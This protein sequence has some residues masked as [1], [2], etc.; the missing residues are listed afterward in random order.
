MR[1]VLPRLRSH[2]ASAISFLRAGSSPFHP[3][4]RAFYFRAGSSPP[5]RVRNPRR[6][7]ASRPQSPR[8]RPAS[9]STTSSVPK[10][11]SA[12]SMEG[13]ILRPGS[14]VRD[15]HHPGS[16]RTAI[17]VSMLSMDGDEGFAAPYTACSSDATTAGRRPGSRRGRNRRN[18]YG[19]CGGGSGS[20]MRGGGRGGGRRQPSYAAPDGADAAA[21]RSPPRRW[22]RA[23][24]GTWSTAWRAR[25]TPRSATA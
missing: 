8:S 4:L 25:S 18:P 13:D 7:L 2:R 5:P 12:L 3:W 19:G 21:S 23:S 16:W 6:P 14:R 9:A 11:A 20:A 15:I 1:R 10:P 22:C 24:R 17:S